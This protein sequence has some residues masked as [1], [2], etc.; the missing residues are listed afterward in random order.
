MFVISVASRLV[1]TSN[2]GGEAPL[3][4]NDWDIEKRTTPPGKYGSLAVALAGSEALTYRLPVTVGDGG[5]TP[6]AMLHVRLFPERSQLATSCWLLKPM[7]AMGVWSTA[8]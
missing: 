6:G 5:V 1:V 3:N 2:A 7:V 8:T 4:L